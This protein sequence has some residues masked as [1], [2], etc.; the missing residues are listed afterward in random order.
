MALCKRVKAALS[1]KFE[2][3]DHIARNLLK[4]EPTTEVPAVPILTFAD[5]EQLSKYDENLHVA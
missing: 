3:S 1:T 4:G 2:S 5:L